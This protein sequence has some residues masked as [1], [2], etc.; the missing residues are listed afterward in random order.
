MKVFFVT[1]LVFDLTLEI[2]F[3][4]LQQ[5]HLNI[6]WIIDLQNVLWVYFEMSK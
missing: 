2:E 4:H 1:I 3:S 5:N 6:I